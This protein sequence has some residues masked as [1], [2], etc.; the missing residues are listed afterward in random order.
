M[1]GTIAL[2]AMLAAAIGALS[3][4]GGGTRYGPGEPEPVT[5]VHPIERAA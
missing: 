4:L 2:I 3:S 1:I 5:E